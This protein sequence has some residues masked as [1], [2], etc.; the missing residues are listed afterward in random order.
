MLARSV[1]SSRHHRT[2]RLLGLIAAGAVALGI[3]AAPA[4]AATC[5]SLS[6]LSS[7]N[8]PACWT[9]FTAN[10]PFNTPLPA[11][12]K[13]AANNAAVT[14]HMTTYGWTMGYSTTGFSLSDNGTRPIYFA[15]PSDPL[16]TIDCTNEEGPNTCQGYNG[17]DVNGAQ[18]HV[19]AGARAGNNWDAHMIIVE[20]DTGLE[21]DLWHASISG[22]TLTAGTG[23]VE[24]IN[25]T[26]GTR[27]NGDA[28]NFALTAGLLRPSELASGHINHALVATIP[29]TNATSPTT[30]YSWPAAG[31]WG[32]YCGQYWNESTTGAPN[33]G[34][35]FKLNMTDAQIAASGAPAWEQ[36]IM[37][38]MAHYGVY[39]EDTEGN[40]HN[41]GIYI[42]TQDPISWTSL[43]QP[44]AW[45]N[46]INSL[47]GQ[48]GTIT[49]NTPI[50]TNKLQ[51][52][53]PCVQQGTCPTAT[54][55][56]D[57]GTD[58]SSVSG[59]SSTAGQTTTTGS[60]DTT[61]TPSAP[62]P[63]SAPLTPSSSPALTAPT[64]VSPTPTAPV[65]V[66]V[67]GLTPPATT[68]AAAPSPTG[69]NQKPHRPVRRTHTGRRRTLT[70]SI[71][72]VR[73]RHPRRGVTRHGATPA[74]L[75]RRRHR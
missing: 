40:W 23:A 17:I 65:T 31:G 27:D 1:R 73:V 57:P 16:V 68:P 52:I 15:T 30:G 5:S 41:E 55:P 35:L 71:A 19:P 13:L 26:N 64:T 49:S 47:G 59:G 14:A 70:A 32:E 67:P 38:A 46:T 4:A 44:N 25:T 63:V 72:T 24:N 22:S 62:P 12:P 33:I 75:T 69:S 34:Q 43:G 56:T 74:R 42:E 60:S 45:D 66:T 3:T 8:Q 20:T 6:T 48:N 54:G 29:C 61:T 18:I 53:D 51:V 11:N 9:P 36:T 58:G 37:T 2:P 7:T 39:A 10:S 21:Y 50:P 28:A